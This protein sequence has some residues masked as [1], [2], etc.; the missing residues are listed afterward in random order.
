MSAPMLRPTGQAAAETELLAQL[1]L[2]ASAS[3]EDVDQLHQAV[4]DYLS[5]APP[6][7]RGWAR[8]QVAA[9]DAAYITLTDP[10]GLEGSALRSPASPPAVVPGGPATPPARRGSAPEAVAPVEVPAERRRRRST[11]R[12][13]P[14]RGGPRG[15]LRVVTPSAH[16]DMKPD[17]R[18][19]QPRPPGRPPRRPRSPAP[20]SRASGRAEPNIWKRIVIGGVGVI[21]SRR[22]R[23]RRQRHRQRH[24][25]RRRSEQRRHGARPQRR[26]GR[27]RGQGRGPDGQDPGGSEGH[28]DAPGA[29]RRVLRRRPVRDVRHL[30]GQA[31]GHRTR[32]HPGPPRPRRGRT[33]TSTTWPTPR[34][35]G[36]RSPPWSPTT[37]R[38][39]TTW[40]SST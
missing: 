1:G 32:E 7:I 22:D 40:A 31:P 13:E 26:P 35:P 2:P 5:A 25:G 3:P 6:E 14:E 29:R 11:S 12:A 36:R 21:G 39:T 27:R 37:S 16:D 23:L 10:A 17:A 33:S 8:A 4:S 38:S 19:A 18:R 20:R 28:R 34:R 15:P 24:A 9:L 30:A